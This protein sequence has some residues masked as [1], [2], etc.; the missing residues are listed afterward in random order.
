MVSASTSSRGTIASTSVAASAVTETEDASPV[1]AAAH[2]NAA[3]SSD[4][5]PAPVSEIS[6]T[7]AVAPQVEAAVRPRSSREVEELRREFRELTHALEARL[8]A[9]ADVDVADEEVGVTPA[10][11]TLTAVVG[12]ARAEENVNRGCREAG[13]DLFS[14]APRTPPVAAAAIPSPCLP[15][16]TPAEEIAPLLS[17]TSSIFHFV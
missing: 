5:A 3:S 16:A 8:S 12:E 9:S 17:G 14:I 7:L 6:D 2:A 13:V 4:A 1:L 15:A 10:S 11:D